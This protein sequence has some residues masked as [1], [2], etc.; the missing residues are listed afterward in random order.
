MRQG[1]GIRSVL[2]MVD[3]KGKRILKAGKPWEE[4]MIDVKPLV[5]GFSISESELHL[6]DDWIMAWR[7][8]IIKANGL[9]P[10][11]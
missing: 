3:S 11:S 10:G 1:Q 2:K 9:K 6:I 7:A 5:E 4:G 8:R